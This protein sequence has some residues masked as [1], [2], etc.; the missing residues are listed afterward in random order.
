MHP[1]ASPSRSWTRT[2]AAFLSSAIPSE[3]I[4]RLNAS[5]HP[6]GPRPRGLVPLLSVLLLVLASCSSSGKG[7]TNPALQSLTLTPSGWQANAV[8]GQS[9]VL[10]TKITDASGAPV[11]GITLSYSSS[12]TTVLRVRNEGGNQAVVTAVRPGT[13]QLTVGLASS[14]SGTASAQS[15]SVQVTVDLAGVAIERSGTP[16]VLTSVGDS[17]VV[18]ARGLDVNGNTVAGAGLEWS[19]AGTGVASVT[20]YAG[21]DSA[22]VVAVGASTDT[23]KVTAALCASGCGAARVVEVRQA[24]ASIQVSPDSASVVAGDSAAFTARA[25]DASGAPVMGAPIRW[26]IGDPTLAAVDTAGV[27]HAWHTGMTQVTAFDHTV[28]AK[29]TVRVVPGPATQLVFTGQP[30]DTA[31]QTALSPAVAVTEQDAYGNVATG[32]ADSVTVALGSNPGGATLRGTTTEAATSGVATFSDLKLNKAGNGYTLVASASGLSSATSAAFDIHNNTPT[33]AAASD[34]T[35]EDSALVVAAPGVLAGATSPAG[36]PLTA[37]LVTGPSHGTLVL[38]ADGSFT[39]TPSANYN[40]ADSFT[41]KVTDGTFTSAAATVSLTITPVNDAPSYTAGSNQTVLEDAGAQSVAWATSVSAGPANESTQ[42]L[43]FTVTNNDSSLFSVQPAIDASGTLTYTTAPDSTGVATVSVQL[44]DD[45]GTANGG[46]DSTVVSTFTIT[47][48]PPAPTIGT[49]TTNYTEVASGASATLSWSGITAATSCSVDNGVGA[50]SCA[51]G[52]T[53]VAPTTTTTYTLTATNITGSST[54]SVAVKVVAAHG[55]VTLSYSG[56]LQHFYVPGGVSSLMITAVG[57][58]GGGANYWND[59]SA[60]GAAGGAGRSVTGIYSVT[61]GWNL[62]VVVGQGGQTVGGDGYGGGG[63]GGSFVFT[64]SATLLVAAGGGGGGGTTSYVNLPGGDGTTT[65][66]GS[67]GKRSGGAGGTGG[68]G[69]AAGNPTTYAT[70]GGGG[71]LSAGG[72]GSGYRGGKGGGQ[73]TA[74]G[75]GAGG[76][77]GEGGSGGYGGG[78]G[79]ANLGGGGGGGY[80]GGGGAFYAS[81]GGGG[82]Y[83]IPGVTPT[84]APGAAGGAGGTSTTVD[85]TAG[86]NGTVTIVW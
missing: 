59:Y 77:G 79:G 65:T 57:A 58:G 12:D 1:Q 24:V 29:A 19:V 64:P 11:S 6:K 53:S 39:Y 74:A 72:S 5:F 4:P 86:T 48:V 66:S 75:G 73:T 35:L 3:S 54:T 71:V 30:H 78:G 16:V 69:G 62:D 22:S 38:N 68:N 13:A 28:N 85:G 43:T 40:G 81:G 34:T 56:S 67:A 21:G 36:N 18:Q 2:L 7:T 52:S 9:A 49:F 51:D 83:S 15:V 25:F 61:P 76:G 46:V 14:E 20:P 31:T 8:V 44:R 32:G 82:M 26:T 47:V 84:T 10:Q 63:G 41:Y 33:A 70:G 55:S 80:S 42:T 60:N 17:A 37:K 45:G 23:V 27:V 50:V